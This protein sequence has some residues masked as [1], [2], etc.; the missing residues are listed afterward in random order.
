MPAV[1]TVNIRA[2]AP[3]DIP[4]LLSLIRRYWEFERIEGFEAL[5]LEMQL[6]RLLGD[7][8]LGAA[9]VAEEKGALLG[10][11]ITVLVL[12]LEHGG[13]M[14]EI[15]EFFVLPEARSRGVGAQLLAAAEAALGARGCVRLQLQLGVDNLAARGFYQHRGYA[16]RA[17]YQLFD[18]TLA[19]ASAATAARSGD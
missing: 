3:R 4:Q 16:A 5:R 12:S 18:K 19:G 8:R 9:W 17:G 13:I 7:P 6:Q 2:A 14:A 1:R 15:D 11:L 10:Y